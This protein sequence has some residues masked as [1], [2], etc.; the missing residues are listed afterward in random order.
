MYPCETFARTVLPVFRWLVAKELIEE[1]NF[2][3]QEAAEKLGT[4]QA[5][6]SYYIHSKRGLRGKTQFEKMLPAL[7]DSAYDVAKDI[8]DGKTS[9]D[10]VVQSFCKV[11]MILRG[12]ES[13]KMSRPEKPSKYIF[14]ASGI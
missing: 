6:I 8:A 12:E 3:Q 1:Y 10:E 14:L 9:P 5:A 13:F 11:C 2:T 7:Q 4:T